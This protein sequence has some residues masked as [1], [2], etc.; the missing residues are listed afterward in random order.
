RLLVK[1]PAGRFQT[2][3]EVA[4]LLEQHLAHL[5]DPAPTSPCGRLVRG[6][7]TDHS[8]D[9]APPSEVVLPLIM[10]ARLKQAVTGGEVRAPGRGWKR[11]PLGA[12]AVALTLV[13]ALG[14][15][16][17]WPPGDSSRPP[18]DGNG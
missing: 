17:A 14:G 1:D 5:N 6:G 12:A 7:I 16:L 15:Y 3:A 4:E 10:K 18:D 2:A 9:V 11:A 13:V 8:P